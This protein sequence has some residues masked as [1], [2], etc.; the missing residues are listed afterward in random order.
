MSNNQEYCGA[1]TVVGCLLAAIAIASIFF[2]WMKNFWIELGQSFSAFGDM[3]GSF[4]SML[5]NVFQVVSLVSLTIA[6]LA[7]AI[8]FSIKYFEMVRDGTAIREWVQSSMGDYEAKMNARFER[9]TKDFTQKIEAFDIRLTEA[10]TEPE[11]APPMPTAAIAGTGMVAA[12]NDRDDL[13]PGDLVAVEIDESTD[14]HEAGP[15][16]TVTMSN[17]L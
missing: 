16:E 14:D 2:K 12:I 17:P 10:M 1:C 4:V 9:V 3:T 13:Q 7:S 5:W 6:G 15:M 8:Y 11:I